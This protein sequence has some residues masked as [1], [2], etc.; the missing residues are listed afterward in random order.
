MERTLLKELVSLIAPGEISTKFEIKDIIEATSA[1]TIYFE[2][3]P[4]LI[5]EALKGKEVVLNGFVNP[6]ELQTFPLKDKQVYLSIRRRRWKEKGKS[7]KSYSNEYKLYR[8][9]MKTTED[10]GDFLKEE[11]SLEVSGEDEFISG[12]VISFIEALMGTGCKFMNFFRVS[13]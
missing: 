13:Q 9:G 1:I 10:F 6:L 12:R 8:E 5:P 11:V 3:K 7:K 4:E 2:E